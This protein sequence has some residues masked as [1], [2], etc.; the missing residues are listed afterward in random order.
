MNDPALRT[1]RNAR[2]EAII[3]LSVWFVALV[4]T[5]GYC[6]LQGYSHAA[7]SFL[8]R[9]GLA[10]EHPAGITETRFG[11]PMWVCYG[12]FIPAVLCSVF[13]FFFGLFGMPD[14]AL[15]VEK[16]ESQS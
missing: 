10:D 9:N 16:E 1:F 5:V 7:D 4:W 8:V 6:Y 14:D 3:V 2:R 15:G 12:I 13:T 11:M